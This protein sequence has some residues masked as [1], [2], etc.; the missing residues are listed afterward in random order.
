MKA[1]F[2]RISALLSAVCGSDPSLRISVHA[3]QSIRRKERGARKAQ[4]PKE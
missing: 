1:G 2:P 3:L 4:N